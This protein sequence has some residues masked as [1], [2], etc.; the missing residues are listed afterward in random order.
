MTDL[1]WLTARPI[2]HRGYHDATAGRIE[3]SL[4]AVAAAIERGFSIEVDLRSAADGVPV[5]FHDDT[6]DRLTGRTGAVRNHSV[7]DLSAITLS[8]SND[9]IPSL[10]DLL[11]LVAGRVGLVIEIKSDFRPNPPYL[12]RIADILS[13]YD[14]PVA[15]MSFDPD[16]VAACRNRVPKLPRGIISGG[17]SP[18]LAYWR[19]FTLMERFVLRHMLHAPRSR[20]DFVAYDIDALPALSPLAMRA[21]SGRP[22]LTWTVRTTFQRQRAARWADQIIF[23]G[24]DA[25]AP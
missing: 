18:R 7:D 15:I 16:L 9:R 23:E 25:D 13:G 17:M 24:F 4:S 2:A 12:D 6:L 21:L 19:R 3:N 20:P 11:D 1:S 14:G 8:G 10:T 22:L 5:V